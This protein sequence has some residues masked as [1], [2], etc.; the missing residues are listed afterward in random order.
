M[1]KCQGD[2][3][4]NDKP[5]SLK[6]RSAVLTS[7]SGAKDWI[8]RAAARAM[9]RAVG[10]KDEDFEKPLICVASPY[11]DV[12]PCN[13]HIDQLAEIVEEKIAKVGG[14]PYMFGTPVITDGETMG[15]EGMKYSLV[16]R[17]WIADSIEMMSEAYAADG[18]IALSGC[19]KTIPASLMPLARNNSIG[20]T[21]YGG[22]ILSGSYK[23]KDLNIVSIF[24]AIG[25]L[26]AGKITKDE[27]HEIECKSCPCA[28]ACGGMYT[29]NTM[30]SAIEALG[31]SVP[32]SAS[33]PA[34]NRN[35]RISEN[36][37][38]DIYRTVDA[39]FFMM[40][41][42][43]RTRDIL[44]RKAFE[45][46]I[47]VVQALGGSTNAV[48][49]LLAIAHEAEVALSIGDFE[50]IGKNVPLIGNFSP[51]GDYM[52]EHLDEIGGI[53]MVMKMLLDAGL[54]HGDCLTVTGKTVAENL[55]DAPDRPENQDVVYAWNKP[56]APAGHHIIIM[57]GNMAAEGSVMK[58]S[59]NLIKQHKGPAR[60]FEC[61]DD[62]MNAIL[63]KKINHGD[64]II[65]RHEG[66]KG[67]PGMREMLSPSSALV[68]AGLGKDVA[69]VTDGRF[70]GGTHGI[71]IGHVAPEAVEGGAIGI[72]QEGDIIDINVEKREI[73][74][75]VEKKILDERR[76]KYKAPHSPYIRGV[77]AKYRTL[78]GSASK[79][80][81]TS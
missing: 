78:V 10:Y 3:C 16:S 41:K 45:N 21:L 18:T 50:T 5:E 49:H 33:R 30:A 77:L 35:G 4:C 34:M 26:S 66:P 47:V 60:V 39:L 19:D 67:G 2:C 75:E 14:R 42:G 24:E 70:S 62:A 22:T 20:I 63:D 65:I 68:G 57:K 64:V 76:K 51:S 12:S 55:E 27:F 25:E 53:P 1:N 28:G 74:I 9:M 43:I 6:K 73:N 52:M 80:A 29:A 69:L 79:G 56:L 46:A 54:I 31:M 44:T 15:T 72:V 7:T 11:S 23:G 17:E 81:V 61:E 40:E 59:G 58:L 13:A 36:K 48:L 32:G 37:I 38:D 8:K 71:M